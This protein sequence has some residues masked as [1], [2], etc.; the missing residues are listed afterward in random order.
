M[1]GLSDPVDPRPSMNSGRP[2]P[3]EGRVRVIA[4]LE[5]LL[6]SSVPTQLAIGAVLRLAGVASV[7]AAGHLSFAFVFALS[8]ADT[9]L[10]IALMV[11]LMLAHGERSGRLW[12]GDRPVTRE[13]LIGL[14]TVPL[15]FVAVGILLN[16]L[17]LLMPWL[18]NVE[19]NPL[20]QM[21]GTPGQAVLFG[22]V[23]IV[24]GG[25]REELQRAFML[26]RFEQYLGG[27]AVGVIVTSIG[28]GFLHGVQGRD[29]MIATGALGAFWAWVYLRRRSSI[30]PVVSHAGF[31]SLEILRVAIVGQ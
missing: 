20:E 10:V 15:I 11:G 5:I 24:A 28:F 27:A 8:I 29:A 13:V 25:V 12:I 3:V 2:E 31:N 7:D 19:T 16:T 18:H 30:A 17:R 9:L 6:C 26:R 22:L 21:A 23:A 4:I 1:W 14:L